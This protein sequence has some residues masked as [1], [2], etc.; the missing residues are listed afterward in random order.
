MTPNS[1]WTCSGSGLV[2]EALSRKFLTGTCSL[3]RTDQVTSVFPVC[4]ERTCDMRCKSK[5]NVQVRCSY[6]RFGNPQV[7]TKVVRVVTGTYVPYLFRRV[8]SALRRDS[9]PGLVKYFTCFAVF[10]QSSSVFSSSVSRLK[11][12]SR[13]VP[14]RC[15]SS[16]AVSDN[17]FVQD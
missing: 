13:S 10:S 16:E 14:C 4:G 2:W 5:A 9:Y 8:L 17:F 15:T 6:E 3:T 12:L 11:L 1:Q 7:T